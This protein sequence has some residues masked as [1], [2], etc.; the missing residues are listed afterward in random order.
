MGLGLW[1]VVLIGFY[2]G[3]LWF[4]HTRGWG[5]NDTRWLVGGVVLGLAFWALVLGWLWME[6]GLEAALQL[7]AWIGILFGPVVLVEVYPKSAD[8]LARVIVIVLLGVGVAEGG[9]IESI[10][11]I[12]LVMMGFTVYWMLRRY[13]K[14]GAEGTTSL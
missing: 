10:T 3:L 6:G 1:F 12:G 7:V 8:A 14:G 11:G 13:R 4:G 2:F 5:Q 9:S